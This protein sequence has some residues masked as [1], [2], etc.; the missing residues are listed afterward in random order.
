[1][2]KKTLLVVGTTLVLLILSCGPRIMVP[3]AVDLKMYEP[4]GIISFTCNAEGEL[5]RYITQKFMEDITRDQKL[6]KLIELGRQEGVLKEVDKTTLDPEAI[7]AIAQKYNVK[8]VITGDLNI[9]DVQPKI[10]IVPGLWGVGAEADVEA[11]L[12]AHMMEAVDGATIWTGSARTK[13]TVGNVSFWSGGHFS[14]DAQDPEASYGDMAQEL[15][16][17]A[18]KDFRVTWHR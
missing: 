14:F 5:D 9:S 13:R 8:S 3:P 17:N 1:M 10:N 11:T 16:R 2:N 6:V 15:I 12:V 4:I 18:T 7:K